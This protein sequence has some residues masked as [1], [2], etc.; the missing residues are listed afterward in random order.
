MS[1]ETKQMTAPKELRIGNFIYNDKKEIYKVT[2]I[3]IEKISN[4]ILLTEEWLLKFGFKE[5][6]D[7]GYKTGVFDKL[8]LSIGFSYC[9]NNK[10]VMIMHEKNTVSHWINKKIEYVHQLQNLYFALT[11]EELTYGG[12]K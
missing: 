11:G 2:W 4:P 1:N 7:F 3:N 6:I 5:F 9:M 10:K 12:N 8:P